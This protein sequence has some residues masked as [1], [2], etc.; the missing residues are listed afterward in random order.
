MGSEFDTEHSEDFRDHKILEHHCETN[1]K[2]LRDQTA[3]MIQLHE[4]LILDAECIEL[5]SIVKEQE[6]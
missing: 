4:A 1:L 3:R 5:R 2:C 6:M